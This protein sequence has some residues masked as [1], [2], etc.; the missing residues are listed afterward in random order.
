M[1][2][3]AFAFRAA[4][5]AARRRLPPAELERVRD[6]VRAVARAQRGDDVLPA[7]VCATLRSTYGSLGQ[8]GRLGFL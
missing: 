2:G 8:D 1:P 4:L 6:A 7:R 5:K 3:G